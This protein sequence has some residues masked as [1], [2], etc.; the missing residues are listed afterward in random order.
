MTDPVDVAPATTGGSTRDTELAPVFETTL[1]DYRSRIDGALEQYLRFAGDCPAQLGEAMRYST[2]AG[3]KRLRPLL[4]LLACEACGGEVEQAVPAGCALELVHTYSLV[5]D[6]LPAMDNDDLRRGRPTSHRVYGEANAILAGDAL[7]TL[8]F[9]IM[10]RDVRPAKT[11]AACCADLAAA[12]GACGMVGGQVV[13]IV[14]QSVD[15]SGVSA[16]DVLELLESI[17]RRKTERLLRCALTIGARIAQA[18]AAIRNSL[19]EYGKRVGLAFQ[20]A[21]DLL[22]VTGDVGR[23]GKDAGKDA[24][25]GKLTYPAL[26][27]V[28]ASQCKAEQLI[29]DGCAAIAVLGDR[30]QVLQSLA[31]FVIERDH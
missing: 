1:A 30:A 21:D 13:D 3:G 20:I 25:H 12:A 19:E 5:H 4:V 8:A 26:L 22:D 28:D 14:A 15:R 9:E 7:L 16:E 11:A 31:R 18:D 17:H 10:A 6:D 27:G 23:M 2:M 24:S 29:Q